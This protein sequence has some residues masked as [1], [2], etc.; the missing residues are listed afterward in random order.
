MLGINLYINFKLISSFLG[1]SL[2]NK[3]LAMGFGTSL[4]GSLSVQLPEGSATD[5]YNTYIYVNI[6]D[7]DNGVTTYEFALPIQVKPNSDML[8]DITSQLL[9]PNGGGSILTSLYSGNS[10]LATQTLLTISAALNNV[11]T[12][13]LNTVTEILFFIFSFYIRV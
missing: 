3:A 8:A 11:N 7:N 10:Q 6:V 12:T 1:Y 5:N 4:D 2:N 13:G 9:D